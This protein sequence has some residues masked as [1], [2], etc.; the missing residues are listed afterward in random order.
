MR[1]QTGLDP[2]RFRVTG[3][4]GDGRRIVSIRIV[5]A[6]RVAEAMR[7]AVKSVRHAVRMAIRNPPVTE[8]DPEN[9]S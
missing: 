1:L 7:E 3:E 6:E 5:G 8:Q 2:A 4:Q 9:C